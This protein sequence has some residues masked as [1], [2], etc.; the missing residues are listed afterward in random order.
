MSPALA[1]WA[2]VEAGGCMNLAFETARNLPLMLTS[3]RPRSA[4]EWD[5]EPWQ[6]QD[7]PGPLRPA[8]LRRGRTGR[9][10]REQAGE[11]DWLPP[12]LDA[13]LPHRCASCDAPATS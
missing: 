9:E 8:R 13:G 5:M 1:T 6:S 7:D 4:R 3:R 11:P 12:Y 2:V 10:L